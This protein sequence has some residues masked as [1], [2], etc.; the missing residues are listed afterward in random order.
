MGPLDPLRGV[1]PDLPRDS[2]PLVQP[3]GPQGRLQQA[4]HVR[5]LVEQSL[6]VNLPI[7]LIFIKCML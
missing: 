5:E 1:A 4:Y 7:I 2:D 6:L 3:D